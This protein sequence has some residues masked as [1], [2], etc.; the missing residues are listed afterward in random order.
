[1]GRQAMPSHRLD[2]RAVQAP[3]QARKRATQKKQRKRSAFLKTLLG[4]R[5]SRL[6]EYVQTR[7]D[8]LAWTW[9]AA[10][11]GKKKIAKEC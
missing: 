9:H 7:G 10:M 11:V 4:E 3:R 5:A 8:W 6:D 2:R 1:T